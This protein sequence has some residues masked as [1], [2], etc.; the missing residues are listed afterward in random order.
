MREPSHTRASARVQSPRLDLCGL[1]GSTDVPDEDESS[2]CCRQNE[3]TGAA[4]GS[5][6]RRPALLSP[7]DSCTTGDDEHLCRLL[8][9]SGAQAAP[10]GRA[11]ECAVGA[12]GAEEPAIAF[13]RGL[14]N[15]AT[16]SAPVLPT[17]LQGIFKVALHLT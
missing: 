10:V 9:G 15:P 4:I 1:G 13:Q 16:A 5:P 3:A 8:L 12:Q 11:V 7:H 6:R 2:F 14:Y 17:F